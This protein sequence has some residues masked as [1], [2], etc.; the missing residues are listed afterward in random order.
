M[1]GEI[2]PFEKE[3]LARIQQELRIHPPPDHTFPRTGTTQRLAVRG[4]KALSELYT[5]RNL[6]ALV[7][8]RDECLKVGDRGLR[9]ALLFCLTACCLKTSRMM[10]FNSDGIGRIQ[11]NG[12]IAQLIVKD[13][14]VFDFLEI[15][16]KG[17]SAGFADIDQRRTQTCAVALSTQSACDLSAIPSTSVDYIFTDPPYG[18]RVQF[19]ESNQVWEAW[20]GLN[21]QWQDEEIIVNSIRGLDEAHWES[22]FR[23]AMEECYRVLKPGR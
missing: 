19:W 12:L 23:K 8:Y 20:L 16:F 11:K 21:T 1:D 14:N 22:L 7:L 17:I 13:V 15:A 4:I 5:P 3:V 18:A 2:S 10:G 6:L 9:N